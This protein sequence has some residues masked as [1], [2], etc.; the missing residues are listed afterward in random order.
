M[1]RGARAMTR[2]RASK[3][4]RQRQQSTNNS[5]G[6]APPS[7]RAHTSARARALEPRPARWGSRSTWTTRR[8][9]GGTPR[10]SGASLADALTAGAPRIRGAQIVVFENAS[11]RA[12]IPASPPPRPASPALPA[13]AAVAPPPLP[14]RFPLRAIDTLCKQAEEQAK[15]QPASA[16]LGSDLGRSPAND[17]AARPGRRSNVSPSATLDAH[18]AP[19]LGGPT[20]APPPSAARDIVPPAFHRREERRR[21]D[22]T[23]TAVAAAADAAPPPLGDPAARSFAAMLAAKDNELAQKDAHLKMIRDRLEMLERDAEAARRKILAAEARAAER[24][25]FP[26]AP[27]GGFFSSRLDERPANG[28][29][30]G[31]AGNAGNAPAGPSSREVSN[32]AALAEA[33]AEL[34]ALRSRAA[35]KEEEAEEARRREEDGRARLRAAEAESA[36]LAAEVRVERRRR[37]AAEEAAERS[38]EGASDGDAKRRRR[39]GGAGAGVGEEVPGG[40]GASR[41]RI[42]IGIGGGENEGP[43]GA[44]A[45]GSGGGRGDP[46]AHGSGAAGAAGIDGADGADG[47]DGG[48]VRPAPAPAAALVLPPPPRGDPSRAAPGASA[49]EGAPLAPPSPRALFALIA[50]EA[51]EALRA[52]LGAGGT[53]ERGTFSDLSPADPSRAALDASLARCSSAL[54]AL[55][56]GVGSG[57]DLARLL[58][59]AIGEAAKRPRAVAAAALESERAASRARGPGRSEPDPLDAVSSALAALAATAKHDPASAS[60]LLDLCGARGDG[61]GGGRGGHGGGAFSSAAPPSVSARS[62]RL[63]PLVPHPASRSARVFA[64]APPEAAALAAGLV[65]GAVPDVSRTGD[66]DRERRERRYEERHDQHHER[67]EHRHERHEHRHSHHH[68]SA[69]SSPSAFL[70]ATGAL[71][72]AATRAGAWRLAGRAFACLALCAACAPALA[73]GRDAFVA[74]ARDGLIADG[75]E[76]PE[77]PPSL[78]D[79]HHSSGGGGAASGAGSDAARR[80]VPPRPET[81]PTPHAGTSGGIAGIAG[82]R[83]SSPSRVPPASVA[84]DALALARLLMAAPAF[85]RFLDEGAGAEGVEPPNPA[86]RPPAPEDRPV[87]ASGSGSGSGSGTAGSGRDGRAASVPAERLLRAI[88]SRLEKGA[89]PKGPHASTQRR[90]SGGAAASA[91]PTRLGESVERERFDSGVGRKMLGRA[92]DEPDAPDA[93]SSDASDDASVAEEALLALATLSH[94][95]WDGWGAATRRH[96]VLARAVRHAAAACDARDA[97]VSRGGDAGEGAADGGGRK[98]AAAAAARR[99]RTRRASSSDARLVERRLKRSLMFVARLLAEPAS[100]PVSLAAL[101]RDG[102]TGAR[103]ARVAGAA[104]AHPEPMPRR[105]GAYFAAV[106][107]LK[108]N[109]AGDEARN[110]GGD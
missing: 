26:P 13:H 100:A 59:R 53:S 90:A 3:S 83:G 77:E 82:P 106:L 81:Q 17:G 8:S 104:R 28:T 39:G 97:F 18:L 91:P 102:E 95:G 64:L 99:A 109:D 108:R 110:D 92:E 46:D 56:S 96:L 16:R 38:R 32:A 68:S 65:S 52:L 49:A 78:R 79:G 93:S 6:G 42:G 87:D 72:S 7:R 15:S 45:A 80:L 85:A 20:P 5:T 58:A 75:V 71:A 10:R 12:R 88:A 48:G 89:D 41:G 84:R 57:P 4:R 36:Q 76:G 31:D 66:V 14:P 74:F 55:A 70:A 40:A 19:G 67:H 105:V 60:A 54:A 30:A 44:A 25:P 73:G 62:S 37:R 1:A 61:G 98:D 101:R 63:G 11:P 21:G 33:K 35:F 94:A 86:T 69:S 103:L 50:G 29:V 43:E 27:A 107:N 2:R 23:T 34:A 51:P 47:T 22:A 24:A 9:S